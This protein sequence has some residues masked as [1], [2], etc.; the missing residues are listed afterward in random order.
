M[1]KFTVVGNQLTGRGL[2]F[3][4]STVVSPKGKADPVA[5]ASLL[6]EMGEAIYLQGRELISCLSG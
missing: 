2:T 3:D 5:G 4:I 6:V 1:D